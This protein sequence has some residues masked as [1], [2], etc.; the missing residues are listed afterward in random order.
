MLLKKTPTVKAHRERAPPRPQ[1]P[2]TWYMF[3]IR[4]KWVQDSGTEINP[5]PTPRDLGRDMFRSATEF[6]QW[7]RRLDK[8][9][10]RSLSVVMG[11]YAAV[12]GVSRGH[13]G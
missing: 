10:V 3:A 7:L 5:W 6:V 8:R 13:Q 2:R 1:P 9:S 4:S 12:A 11:V